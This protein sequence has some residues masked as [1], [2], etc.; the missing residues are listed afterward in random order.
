MNIVAERFIELC[1]IERK[2]ALNEQ[3]VKE[4]NE[5][6]DYLE[7]L[8]WEKAKLKNLSLLASMTDD[9]EWQ[10]NLCKEIDQLNH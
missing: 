7:R 6:L 10:L 2:R 8:E 1:L 3:E 5:S 9:S 4:L